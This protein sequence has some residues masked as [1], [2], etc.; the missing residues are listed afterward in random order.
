MKQNDNLISYI[1]IPYLL[2]VILHILLTLPMDVPIIWPDEFAYLFFGKYIAGYENI[3]QIPRIELTGSFGYSVLLAPVF[4]LISEP[5]KA[6]STILILNSILGSTLYIGLF[7]LLKQLFEA[8]NKRAM[9][10]SFIVCLYPAYLLQTDVALTDAVTPAFFVF[11]VVLFNQFIKKQTILYGLLFAVIAGYLNWIHIR[12]LPFTIISV[13]FLISLVYYKRIPIFQ[14]GIAIVTMLIMIL[15]GII[16]G[17]HL[18]YAISG[19][20][21]KSQRITVSLIQVAEVLLIFMLLGSSLYF[22][23]RKYYLLMLFTVLGLL[24]GILASTSFSSLWLSSTFGLAILILLMMTKR[25]KF[26]QAFW[27]FGIMMFVASFTYFVL[28]DFGYYTIVTERIM[29][30]F[31]NASG[32]LFYA[33]FSTYS[34]FLM[35]LIFMIFQ[36]WSN[37]IIEVPA[38]EYTDIFSEEKTSVFSF[39]KLLDNPTSLTLLFIISSAFLMIFITIFPSKLQISHYRADHLFYGRY[40][41]VVLAS[42]M[43][44]GIYKLIYADAKEFLVSTLGAWLFFIIL[45]F[46]MIL[47]YDNIIPSE[48]S[49]RSVLSFFPLRAVLGNINIMLFFL[50]SL[51]VSIVTVLLFRF[52]TSW[53][54]SVL[55]L[56]FLSFTTFTYIYVNYY[57]QAEKKQR[58]KLIGFVNEHFPDIDSLSYDRRIF[59]EASQNGL[60]YV[61]LMPLKR[62]NFFTSKSAKPKSDLIIAGSDFGGKNNALLLD[63]E[64]DGNDHLW[65]QRSAISSKMEENL[66][67]SF[68]DLPLNAKYVGGVLRT[69]LHN[70]KWINGKT[71]IITNLS[72]PDSIFTVEIEIASSSTK[73]HNLIIWLDNKELF[74]K[75]IQNGGWRY[76]LSIKADS[77]I[78]KLDFKLFSDL[79]RDKSNNNRLSGIVINSFVLKSPKIYET[80]ISESLLPNYEPSLYEDI[81]YV[82]YP[83]RNIDFSLLEFS[84]GDTI[85]IPM[86]IKNQGIKPIVFDD[87]EDNQLYIGY[88]WHDF[89]LKSEK[90]Q[91]IHPEF[92]SGVILPGQ[93]KEVWV[94]IIAPDFPKKFFMEFKLLSKKQVII[95]PKLKRNYLFDVKSNFL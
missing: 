74:N 95:N 71:E 17:D 46:T 53:G 63:I 93:E 2:L 29:I 85:I 30:W 32:S 10:I 90:F 48:L 87:D 12:M 65:I 15:L 41:E 70:G 60:S 69:G 59:T 4:M 18:T 39:Y 54:K 1:L 7:L 9:L 81:D 5:N 47:T 91:Y 43:A 6:Y 44:I 28:P 20:L 94:K 67:P 21:E 16:I 66:F 86:N 68:Y 51:I 52:N 73:P 24:G 61:W 13:F 19:A 80:S 77:L 8:E 92:L 57:H 40:V 33:L 49:F 35:G 64:H 55:A 62:F 84:P 31:V 26:K 3:Q 58:N 23:L 36:I 50:A 27:A 34:L 42:F 38:V 78:D 79:T 11:G 14:T 83:R 75:D 37:A 45:T 25:V 76:T 82:I 22:M 89:V 88:F 72:K 56:A